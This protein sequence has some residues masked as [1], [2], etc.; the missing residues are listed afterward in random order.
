MTTCIKKIADS[1]GA[2]CINSVYLKANASSRAPSVW[3]L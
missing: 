3:P 2:I 1:G